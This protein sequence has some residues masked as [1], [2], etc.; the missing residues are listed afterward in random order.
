ME[1]LSPIQVCANGPASISEGTREKKGDKI[2][3]KYTLKSH[4]A[5]CYLG[6]YLNS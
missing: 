5:T 4:E 3:L 1:G 6:V 2:T